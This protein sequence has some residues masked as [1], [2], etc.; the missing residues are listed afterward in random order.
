M[1]KTSSFDLELARIRTAR[2]EPEL[3][4]SIT[5]RMCPS[6]PCVAACPRNAL[7]QDP[8][9]GTILL[10][11]ALCSGCGWCIEACEFGAI[12]MDIRTK[13]VVVCDLCP[14]LPQPRCVELCPRQALSLAT[15]SQVATRNRD[16]AAQR[17]LL[18]TAS[19]APK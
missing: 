11:K 3:V 19:R 1:A 12:S 17:Q 5:C 2:P 15:T 10:N 6:P 13:S 9:K 18:E 14:E 16:R 8:A 4:I 7:S